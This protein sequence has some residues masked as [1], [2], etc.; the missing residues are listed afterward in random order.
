MFLLPWYRHFFLGARNKIGSVYNECEDIWSDFIRPIHR[1]V[2]EEEDKFV[3]QPVDRCIHPTTISKSGENIDLSRPKDQ[4][5][6]QFYRSIHHRLFRIFFIDRKCKYF[7]A[8]NRY[9]KINY[10]AFL[11]GDTDII[12]V[13]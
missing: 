2:E 13:K 6:R 1:S 7:T 11:R 9:E 12:R 8:K 4:F 10:A 3:I 5:H